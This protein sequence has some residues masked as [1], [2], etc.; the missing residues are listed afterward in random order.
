MT[1]I[2]E[3]TSYQ[4]TASV[5]NARPTHNTTVT[6]TATLTNNG[7]PVAGATL[8]TVWNYKT[9]MSAC[10]GGPSAANGMAS[11]ARDISRATSGYTV[12]IDVTMTYQG[13][14]YRATTSFTP[15]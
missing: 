13:K 3:A 12:T 7:Q 11:C 5:S 1:P 14:Q 10:S 15:Q 8:D 2:T 9:T 6:V 4:V